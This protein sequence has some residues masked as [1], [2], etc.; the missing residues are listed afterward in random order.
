MRDVMHHLALPS[1]NRY[2]HR[3]GYD[4][5]A[6]DLDSDG[7]GANAGAQ[8]AK[9]AKIRLLQDA[10]AS[11]PLAVWLDADVLLL[12]TDENIASHLQPDDFQALALEHVPYEQRVNPNTGVW[13]LRS[14]ATAFAFL[15]TVAELGPQPGPWADQGAVLAA[16]GWHRGDSRY[17][18]AKPGPGNAFLAGT[19]WLPPGWNQPY[20][21]DRDDAESYN[22]VADS[23]T[24]RPSVRL[25]HA[26][27][28]MGMTP[29]ARYR[30]MT[31]VAATLPGV[32][33]NGGETG[34]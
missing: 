34:S 33:S 29:D 27:H 30:S 4:V 24:D 18:G 28:F 23:Y 31:R 19:S 10:L 21:E 14:S 11:Y 12:R 16:L 25:P 32:S 1:F 5:R 7:A 9:W 8:N 17:R 13:V 6:E 26:L 22:S 20:L 2:A 15:D 3:W